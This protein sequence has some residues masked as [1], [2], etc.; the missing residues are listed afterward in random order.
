[1]YIGEYLPYIFF[2]PCFP[3]IRGPLDFDEMGGSVWSKNSARPVLLWEQGQN[4]KLIAQQM[5]VLTDDPTEPTKLTHKIVFA[6]NPLATI[7]YYPEIARYCTLAKI[8]EGYWVTGFNCG[9]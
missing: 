4:G 8:G 3:C 9:G 2:P 1:M 5:S 6:F 7:V